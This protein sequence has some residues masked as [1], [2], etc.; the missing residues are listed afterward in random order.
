M[1]WLIYKSEG[2]DGR[3][4]A[5]NVGIIMPGVTREFGHTHK[6]A[7]RLL[8]ALE[9][10]QARGSL[11]SLIPNRAQRLELLRAMSRHGLVQWDR[12]LR[13]YALTP[14]GKQCLG[15][16]Q[17]AAN[18]RVHGATGTSGSSNTAPGGNTHDRHGLRELSHFAHY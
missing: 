8:S 15:E 18:A 17:A 9:H 3:S 11:L 2:P 1:D 7:E 6:S 13:K 4:I 12:A 10:L 16:Y 14:L 5:S